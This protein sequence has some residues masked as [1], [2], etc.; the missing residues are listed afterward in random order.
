M[1]KI[2]LQ[3]KAIQLLNGFF[4]LLLSRIL[5]AQECDATKAK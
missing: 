4:I 2:N 1:M 3:L 5:A